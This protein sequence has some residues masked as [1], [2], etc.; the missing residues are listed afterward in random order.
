MFFD[1]DGEK[2]EDKTY[3]SPN[4]FESLRNYLLKACYPTPSVK[5]TKKTTDYGYFP[6]GYKKFTVYRGHLHPKVPEL[7]D[8]VV[9]IYGQFIESND[10][11][12]NDDGIIDYKKPLRMLRE[13]FDEYEPRKYSYEEDDRIGHMIIR[14]GDNSKYNGNNQVISVYFKSESKI[15]ET[16]DE[17]FDECKRSGV[18]N[19]IQI[20]LGISMLPLVN[21][22]EE[23]LNERKKKQLDI[24]PY[25]FLDTAEWVNMKIPIRTV[26][27]NLIESLE[28]DSQL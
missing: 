28:A 17:I 12:E 7:S 21:E 2:I 23:Q 9:C 1:E 19:N 25:R 14:N 26:E 16:L 11:Y 24:V 3:W 6:D 5:I 27:I 15:I 13:Y 10:D 8:V 18:S 4:T 20:E 22:S